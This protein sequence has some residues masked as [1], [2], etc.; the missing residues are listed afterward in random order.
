MK[1]LKVIA[2]AVG[3]WVYPL[4]VVKLVELSFS[5]FPTW[6]L[7]MIGVLSFVIGLGLSSY[8]TDDLERK[9]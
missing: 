7:I 8:L 3:L 6:G 2:V 5:A 4:T 1:V 9:K